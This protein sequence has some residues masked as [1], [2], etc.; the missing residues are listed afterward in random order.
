MPTAAWALFQQRG[1][2]RIEEFLGGRGH[3]RLE[4]F[5]AIGAT[6]LVIS[7]SFTPG[8]RFSYSSNARSAISRASTISFSH[9]P[10]V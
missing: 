8:Q 5:L 9:W 3:Q 1:E 6:E 4:Q 10:L 2:V 7:H